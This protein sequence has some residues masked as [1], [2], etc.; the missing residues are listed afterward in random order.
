M[1][2]YLDSKV[3]GRL[4]NATILYRSS[5]CRFRP[6]QFSSALTSV[7][8]SKY[9]AKNPWNSSLVYAQ[10]TNEPSFR[11]IA[12]L[13]FLEI[14]VQKTTGMLGFWSPAGNQPLRLCR[15][16]LHAEEAWRPLDGG[17]ESSG[18][19]RSPGSLFGLVCAENRPLTWFLPFLCQM[20]RV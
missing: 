3:T 9:K 7:L 18:F 20:G 17:L 13:C 1:F 5:I 2:H 15:G 16:E 10:Q 8:R 11:I 12:V 14:L 4:A 19:M 6:S